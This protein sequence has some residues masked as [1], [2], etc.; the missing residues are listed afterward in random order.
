MGSSSAPTTNSRVLI[1]DDDPEWREAL[2][3]VFS[4]DDEACELAASAP[5][6]LA[7]LAQGDFDVVICDVRMEGMDGL[8]L[9]DRVKKSQPALPVIMIT[10][11]GQISDAV[12]AI[13]GGAF[14][15]VTKPCDIEELRTLVVGAIG[16]KR[17]QSSDASTRPTRPPPARAKAGE[18]V[19]NGSAMRALAASVER[20][21]TS[22]APVLISGE[23]GVGKELVA[24]AIHEGSDRRDRPFVAVNTS[25]VNH[26][27]FES[28][29]FGHVRGAFT[30][31]A[32]GR[33]GLL[34]EADGGTLLLDEIGDMPMS[35]QAKL[36]RVLQFGEVRPVGSDRVHFVDVRVIA[37][38]H[39]D[40]VALVREGRFREDLYFRLNVLPLAVP[41]LRERREDIPA[42][43][44]HFLEQACLR[45]PLSPVRSIS[46]EALRALSSAPW[47]GNIRE[48]AS[49]IERAVVFSS[50]ETLDVRHMSALSSTDATV[51]WWV[52]PSHEMWTLKRLNHAYVQ[53]VMGEAAGNKHRCAEILG[54]DL[55]TLYRWQRVQHDGG[56]PSDP[57]TAG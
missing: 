43:A 5:A 26:D 13:K 35:M 41:P 49:A 46:D 3:L 42:L 48:L 40:L 54:I 51:P 19:G 14:E 7:L 24:R 8:E 27:L 25:A 45:A 17:R 22:S 52:P 16:D 57:P 38:T 20:L 33:K 11:V 32:Q 53:W 12:R 21:S 44:A 55:S 29:V 28:E 31:A 50:D 23:T 47:P 37:A 56:T 36:L 1:V 15:Y 6:A 30:G 34:T 10:G 18:L 2:R 4:R 9:L 39:R